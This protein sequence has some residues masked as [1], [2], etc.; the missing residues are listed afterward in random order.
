[1]KRESTINCHFQFISDLKG[2]SLRLQGVVKP[3]LGMS[4]KIVKVFDLF[5]CHVISRRYL[6]SVP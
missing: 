1:M 6:N 2:E 3:D 5:H 4:D